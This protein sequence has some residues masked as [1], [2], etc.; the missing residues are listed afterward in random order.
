MSDAFRWIEPPENRVARIAGR[1]PLIV[2]IPHA[3]ESIPPGADWLASLPRPLFL[4]DLDR[5]VDRLYEPALLSLGIRGLVARFH[6]YGGDLNRYPDDVDAASVEGVATPAGKFPHGFLWQ[7]STFGHPILGA[8]VSAAL[9]ARLVR[10]GHDRF[11]AAFAEALTELRARGAAGLLHLDLH[12]MPS[13]ATEAHS[14][15]GSARARPDIVV[16]DWEGRSARPE[17]RDAVVAA[18]ER[19]GFEVTV[20]WPYK[21]GRIT[22]RYGHP[23]TG[24][25]TIQIEL[26][27][28]LYL[29]ESTAEPGAGF[30]A[31]RA[32]LY[33]ALRHLVSALGWGV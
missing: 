3:G 30:E 1:R 4:G 29:D 7:R 25:E 2:T 17:T 13:R 28:R 11:H 23:E 27:R 15:G 18:Y 20:N 24:H 33:D 31:T 32:R 16:S 10:E 14:D 12:S 9:H 8:P 26:N 5:F 22:Q 6:R 21:G 19:A